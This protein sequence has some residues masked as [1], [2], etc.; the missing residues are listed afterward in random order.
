MRYVT[1]VSGTKE[2]RKQRPG[3]EKRGNSKDRKA[4]KIWM[5]SPMAPFGGDGTR[6]R[7]V[8]CGDWLSY[9]TVE[10]DRIVPGGSYRRENVQ[11]A[12]RRD[13]LARS[14]DAA[15]SF[16]SAPALQPA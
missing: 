16:T 13:N 4:R 9:A 12:C 11:P 1:Y 10:A 8:H 14:D 3:G 15:W 5:L 7:C 2:A 6:V